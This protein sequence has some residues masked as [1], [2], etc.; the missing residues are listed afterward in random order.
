MNKLL[1]WGLRSIIFSL[2]ILG[3]GAFCFYARMLLAND[4]MAIFSAIGTVSGLI[5]TVAGLWAGYVFPEA[6]KIVFSG[7]ATK[8]KAG[9]VR[10]YESILIPVVIALICVIVSLAAPTARC[11][12]KLTGPSDGMISVYK[13]IAGGVIF[14]L[15]CILGWAIL[16]IITPSIHCW[17][18]MRQRVKGDA[19]ADE[20]DP[21]PG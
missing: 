4:L 5:F 13:A 19:I 2:A 16:K 14:I 8:E 18:S 9:Q 10:E 3:L 6:I 11:I 17:A 12:L 21:K 15:F 1:L 20:R 7:M